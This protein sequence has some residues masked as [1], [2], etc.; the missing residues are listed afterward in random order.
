MNN[1]MFAD[2]VNSHAG[3][4][5]LVDW[6]AMAN[7][8]LDQISSGDGIHPVIGSDIYAQAVKQAIDGPIAAGH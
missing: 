1:Q 3:N 6:D 7:Q 2:Y 4:T 8:H 5:V